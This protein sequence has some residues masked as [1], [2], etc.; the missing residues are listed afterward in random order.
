MSGGF[1]GEWGQDEVSGYCL[2]V[3]GRRREILMVLVGHGTK[4]AR[5]LMAFTLALLPRE[6]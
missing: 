3:L 5:V 1:S 6:T 4:Q 2:V